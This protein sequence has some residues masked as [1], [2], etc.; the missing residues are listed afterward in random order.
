[1][2]STGAATGLTSAEAERRLA[3]SGTNAIQDVAQ[4][5][6]YR[7][8]GKLWAPVPWMLEAAILLQ[9]GLGEY[10]EA[11]GRGRPPHR[12]MHWAQ[13]LPYWAGGAAG[14]GTGAR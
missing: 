9:L 10:F 5:P 12:P 3:S 4:N 13:P 8:L 11:A 2:S 7:A 1:M 14:G 6:V